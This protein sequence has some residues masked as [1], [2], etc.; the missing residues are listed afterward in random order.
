MTNR[1]NGSTV[2]DGCL[3]ELPDPRDL[4]EFIMVA[5][6]TDDNQIATLHYCTR[7]DASHR[8]CA[9][10][11]LTPDRVRGL[12]GF[13]AGDREFNLIVPTE[14]IVDAGG[15]AEVVDALTD[16]AGDGAELATWGRELVAVRLLVRDGQAVGVSCEYNAAP[17]FTTCYAHPGGEFIIESSM[18]APTD[19]LADDGGVN[20]PLDEAGAPAKA[21]RAELVSVWPDV[22]AAA[23][24]LNPNPDHHPVQA[25]LRSTAGRYP[26]VSVE[27]AY[28]HKRF[29][30]VFDHL[31]E[32]LDWTWRS[33]PGD[34]EVWPRPDGQSDGQSDPPAQESA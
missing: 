17:R 10:A 20:P 31:P 21:A 8:R 11:M 24:E 27:F 4:R 3:G 6:M 7:S 23:D 26:S 16:Q 5:A 14:Q 29:A 25:V 12:P 19:L 1:P 28:G 2:C 34:S 22:S 9:A 13:D 33:H 15:A 30:R 32:D 18:R